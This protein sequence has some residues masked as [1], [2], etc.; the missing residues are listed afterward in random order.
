MFLITY[1]LYKAWEEFIVKQAGGW[2]NLSFP[3]HSRGCPALVPLVLGGTEPAL[4]VVEGAGT[5]I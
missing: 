2:P 1:G 5:F 4:S 3:Y